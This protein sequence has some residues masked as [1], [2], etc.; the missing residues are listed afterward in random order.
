MDQLT[1]TT[2]QPRSRAQV[3]RDMV[4]V[5]LAVNETGPKIS[6]ILKAN[7]LAL[8][9]DWSKI[10]PHW[11]IATV[12]DEVIGCCQVVMSKPVG[13]VEF[14][15]VHPEVPFKLR[16]IALRKL[17]YQ[18][19]GTLHHAGCQYVAGMVSTKNKKFFNVIEKMNF[20]KIDVADL[21]VRKIA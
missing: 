21:V 8:E 17:G 10:F 2:A 19:M 18:A 16:A 14:L 12:D 9:A 15:Y 5:R 7:G 6:E 11:L 1:V 13:Y 20:S 4:E 3:I